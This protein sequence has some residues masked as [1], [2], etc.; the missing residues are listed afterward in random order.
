MSRR[1]SNELR[2]TMAEVEPVTAGGNQENNFFCKLD[3][4][5]TAKAS[6]ILE[7]AGLRRD[8]PLIDQLTNG[9]NLSEQQRSRNN[10]RTFSMQPGS[11]TAPPGI[12]TPG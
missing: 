12:V 2:E 6:G 1:P 9:K 4:A 5:G 11:Q 8:D 3:G 7:S 10:S